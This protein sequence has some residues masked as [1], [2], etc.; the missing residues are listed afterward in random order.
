MYSRAIEFA[1][2]KI[3]ADYHVNICVEEK[4][5]DTIEFSVTADSHD[6]VINAVQHIQ[7]EFCDVSSTQ[8]SI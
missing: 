6:S 1:T 8:V 7:G 5:G 2:K 4:I 3:G